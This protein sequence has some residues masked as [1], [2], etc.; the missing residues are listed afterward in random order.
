ME[1]LLTL[2][3]LVAF[4]LSYLAIP[5]IIRLAHTNNWMDT[6]GG[7]KQHEAPTPSLGGIAIFAG[8]WVSTLAFLAIQDKLIHILPVIIA[9][10]VLF[11]IG[12]KDDLKEVSAIKKLFIQLSVASLLFEFDIC[13]L[14]SL[15]GL[16]QIHELP[17]VLDFFLSV[18]TTTLIINAYNLIDGINGLSGSL[19]VL[20]SITFALLFLANG[21]ILWAAIALN[22]A[23]A[24]LGFLRY[25][26]GKAVIFMGDNGSTFVGM[27]IS[28]LFYQLIHINYPVGNMFATGLAIIS[29]PVFDLIRVFIFRISQK[30]GPFSPDRSHI[31]HI[32]L[33]KLKDVN[34]VVYCIIGLNVFALFMLW[35]SS[36]FM[37][38]L[39]LIF[40]LGTTIWIFPLAIKNLNLAK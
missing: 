17:L 5:R 21:Q 3:I 23:A 39:L 6:P 34:T 27:I 38:L 12:L 16:L 2:S 36:L 9:G 29:I 14:N 30:R 35:V 37:P 11:L 7:R 10:T 24:T 18:L 25:N 13:R 40:F 22:L 33:N 32:L 31:H 19:T 4:T 28:I 26:F 20:S 1:I 8:F 15:Y